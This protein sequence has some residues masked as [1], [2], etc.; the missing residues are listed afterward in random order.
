MHSALECIRVKTEFDAV[1]LIK[2][3]ELDRRS[4]LICDWI[5]SPH[6]IDEYDAAIWQFELLSV[7]LEVL[8]HR[9]FDLLR[10]Q[11]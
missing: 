4:V 8:P 10:L 3:N 11:N 9:L 1:L 6:F 5:L 2:V 7:L